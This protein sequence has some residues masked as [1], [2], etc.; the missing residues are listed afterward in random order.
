MKNIK[1]FELKKIQTDFPKQKLT[2]SKLSSEFIRQFYS[3]DIE[4]YES[5]FILMLNRANETIG[6]AKIS[7]GGICGTIVDVKLVAKF[8][9]DSLASGIIIAHNHPSGNLQPSQADIQITNKIK[10]IVK[11]LDSTLLDHII[12]TKE[13]YYSLSDEG[14]I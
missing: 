7:Q 11:L 8:V 12:L 2:S 14:K 5:F 10:E 9:V 4:I 1:L 6:Y 3:D 13:S